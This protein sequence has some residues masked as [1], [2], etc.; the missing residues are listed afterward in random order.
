[1]HVRVA[2]LIR[3]QLGGT[4]YCQDGGAIALHIGKV[5]RLGLGQ[6]QIVDSAVGRVSSSEEIPLSALASEM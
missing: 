3:A 4:V 5:Q 6:A 2:I 1:M